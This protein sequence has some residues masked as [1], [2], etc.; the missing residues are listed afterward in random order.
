MCQV[1]KWYIWR[2]VLVDPVLKGIML[3]KS[4]YLELV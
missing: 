4:K 3:E 2:E 1:K